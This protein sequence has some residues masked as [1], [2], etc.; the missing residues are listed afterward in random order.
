MGRREY[1]GGLD[2]RREAEAKI[3]MTADDALGA[4]S[5]HRP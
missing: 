3:G 5:Y 2:I 4:R 1:P